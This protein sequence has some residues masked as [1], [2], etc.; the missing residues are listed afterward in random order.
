[1]EISLVETHG[2]SV[3]VPRLVSSAATP[4]TLYPASLVCLRVQPESLANP[5]IRFAVAEVFTAH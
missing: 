5:A 4:G 1:V 3:F 2:K